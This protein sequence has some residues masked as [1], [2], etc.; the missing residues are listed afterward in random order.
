MGKFCFAYNRCFIKTSE[1]TIGLFVS[2]FS[3]SFFFACT[4]CTI[5]K[6]RLYKPGQKLQDTTIL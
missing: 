2:F 3:L 6:L 4:G 5:E 1:G